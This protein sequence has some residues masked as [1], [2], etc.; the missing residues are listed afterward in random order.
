MRRS[1]DKSAS[2]AQLAT[3]AQPPPPCQYWLA[4]PPENHLDELTAREREVLDLV[5][6]GLTNEEIAGRLGVT[7]AGVKYH[8][9]QILS[10]LG[11]ATREEAAATAIHVAGAFPDGPSGQ[12]RRGRWWAA[13]PLAAKAA[14]VAVMVA[15]VGGLGVLAWGVVLTSGETEMFRVEGAAMAPTL[16]HGMEVEVIPYEGRLPEQG[17]IIVFRAPTSPNRDFIKRIIGLPG[18]TIEITPEGDVIL[19]DET[20]SEPYIMGTTNCSNECEGPIAIPAEGSL[21][22]RAECGST[23]CYFVMGD[24]RQ[25]SSD[26]RQGWLVPLENIHGWVEPPP[27]PTP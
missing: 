3:S 7:E 18:D 26:S 15:T 2:F 14:G 12:P 16:S 22:A 5:R 17:D 21:E 19:N 20:L 4:M 9:S 11:V 27:S 8:V 24:N 25:N 1:A 10:K 6:L 23:S 13:L